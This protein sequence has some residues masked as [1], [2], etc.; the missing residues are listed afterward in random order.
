M[1]GKAQSAGGVAARRGLVSGVQLCGVAENNSSGVEG[2]RKLDESTDSESDFASAGRSAGGVAAPRGLFSGVQ[3]VAEHNSSSVEG[4]R[5]G[6]SVLLRTEEWAV[7]A[8]ALIV[9]T[10]FNHAMPPRPLP[11]SGPASHTRVEIAKLEPSSL[12]LPRHYHY[13]CCYYQSLCCCLTTTTTL[14]LPF[15]SRCQ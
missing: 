6:L 15:S 3:R 7:R 11:F 5:R 8:Q 14:L 2:R 12:S 10:M 1:R 4:L 13:H 9:H